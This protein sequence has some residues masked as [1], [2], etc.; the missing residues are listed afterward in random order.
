MAA[1]FLGSYGEAYRYLKDAERSE[2]A[3]LVVQAR[4]SLDKV[5]LGIAKVIG[6]EKTERHCLVRA[7]VRACV[8]SWWLTLAIYRQEEAVS[9]MYVY[10]HA[11]HY[12]PHT[13]SVERALESHEPFVVLSPGDIKVPLPAM[14]ST[15]RRPAAPAATSASASAGGAAQPS[16]ATGD[17]AGAAVASSLA[18]PASEDGEAEAVAVPPSLAALLRNE[19]LAHEILLNPDFK[20]EDRKPGGEH[21][22]GP[23]AQQ[24]AQVR[25][26]RRWSKE[27][28][29]GMK[30]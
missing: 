15:P 16:P 6:R 3:A 24:F 13:Q 29:E 9:D 2:Q 5:K 4:L 8:T 21:G 14:G 20:L 1:S 22:E 25:F 19:F 17:E 23:M 28:G 30:E 12:T 10:I 27:G 11:Y 26:V 7:G 18:G